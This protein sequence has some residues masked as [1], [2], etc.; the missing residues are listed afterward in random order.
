MLPV[1]YVLR[2][3]TNAKHS[4]FPI[5]PTQVHASLGDVYADLHCEREAIVELE[6]AIAIREHL[7]PGPAGELIRG[8]THKTLAGLYEKIGV[9]VL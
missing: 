7:N 8:K 9:S 1:Q 5:L 3:L 2:G 4:T 6:K